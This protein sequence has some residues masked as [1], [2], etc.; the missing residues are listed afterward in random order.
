MK[1]SKYFFLLSL[2]A[3][4]LY[5]SAFP[6]IF[7]PSFPPGALIGIF[8]FLKNLSTF[9]TCKHP[10]D[11]H[12]LR[13]DLMHLLAFSLGH[14]IF[15]FYWLAHT[16]EVFGSL[17]PIVSH[18]LGLLFS[19]I[20]LPQYLVFILAMHLITKVIDRRES[21]FFPLLIAFFLTILEYYTPQQFPAHLGHPWL[22]LH[23]Y[24]PF[25]PIGG[26]PF[27]SFISFFRN[28]SL[29]TDNIHYIVSLPAN[30]KI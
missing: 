8:I 21:S 1:Q 4:L 27:Y 5:A 24:L 18:L 6:I 11:H 20:I 19:L 12:P 29:F 26:A 9:S 16:M 22:H 17:S 23:P 7:S 15:G 14:C 13:H 28:Y 25:A 2:I 10:P 3:G 30:A